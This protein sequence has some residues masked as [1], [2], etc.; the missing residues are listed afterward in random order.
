MA[1][2]Q[3]ADTCDLE[4]FDAGLFEHLTQGGRRPLDR[5]TA[6]FYFERSPFFDPASSNTLARQ[7]GL[8]PCMPG[9]LESLPPGVEFVV[10]VDG[11][12]SLFVIRKQLRRRPPEAPTPLSHYHVVGPVVHQAPTMHRVLTAR[13]ARLAASLHEGF[14]RLQ[15]DLDPLSHIIKQEE[16]KH[17]AAAV[18]AAAAAALAAASARAA[19]A[20]TATG[21]PSATPT[22]TSALSPTPAAAAAAAISFTQPEPV[23]VRRQLGTAALERWSKT[24][25][26]IINAL[27]Q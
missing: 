15:N 8:E 14:D 10:E 2:P 27:R 9:V 16:K 18:K 17:A 19:T 5:Y 3:L 26:I 23:P 13:I 12:P 11:P 25:R 21:L 20:A 24:D 4:W 6:M 1:Q 22:R 7:R